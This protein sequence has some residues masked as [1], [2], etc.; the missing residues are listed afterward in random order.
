MNSADRLLQSAVLASSQSAEL[1]AEKT[2]PFIILSIHT[3]IIAS[4]V[5]LMLLNLNYFSIVLL[6]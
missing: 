3:S 5:D 1:S 4:V 6:L 2:L